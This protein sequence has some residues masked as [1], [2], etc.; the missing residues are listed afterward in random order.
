M[1]A[2]VSP[3]PRS[4]LALGLLA[5]LLVAACAAPAAPGPSAPAKPAGQPSA[6]A[7][8]AAAPA[9][10]GAQPSPA[11]PAQP[12]GQAA[13]VRV[14][15][16]GSLSDSG[17]FI[18]LDRGYW[19]EQGLTVDLVP[20]DNI[21]LMIPA[22][23]TAQIEVGAGSTAPGLFNAVRRDVPL[24][25]VADK[26]NAAPGFGF[27]ALVLRKDL[28]DSGAIRDFPDLRG[29][30]VAVVGLYQ[31]A[32]ASL[33]QGLARAGVADNEVNI[34]EMPFPDI[35]AAL[36]NRNID[37]GSL[38]EPFVAA[39]VGNG[40]G[41]RWK[42]TDETYPNYQIAMLLYA[43]HFAAP[44]QR[45][46]AERFMIGYLKGVRDYNDAFVKNQGRDAVI[47]ILI[48]HTPVKNRAQ[49][50]AIVPAG[51]RPNGRV[52][53]E[54]IKADQDWY[55]AAGQQSE[56]VDVDAIVDHSYVDNAVRVLGPYSATP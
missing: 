52:N 38:I 7:P 46:A 19:Q 4:S 2:I 18:A 48:K 1:L 28:A 5:G 10:V 35:M 36:G 37:V 14:G 53:V 22:M 45:S 44:A 32:H 16:I 47:D 21:G 27:S 42:G 41:V 39:A 20:F 24:K 25:I 13:P 11:A 6:A 40:V 56:K 43:P 17:L 51:L 55:F 3:W 33:H 31:S 15:T 30:T 9:A 29:K 26:G 12:A 50:D 23:G 34:I 49:Y 54:T 8:T